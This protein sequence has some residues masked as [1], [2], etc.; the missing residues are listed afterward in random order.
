MKR[1][2]GDGGRWQATKKIWSLLTPPERKGA[3]ALLGLM[4]IGMALETLGV[5]LVIPALALLTGDYSGQSYPALQRLVRSLGNPAP[6]TLIIGGMLTLVGVYA[7]KAA[8]LAFLAWRQMRF[9]FG[10][11]I[12]LSQR[13]FTIYLRQ[14]YAFHLQRNSAQLIR[15]VTTEVSIFTASGILPCT[16]LL[17]E[18]LVLAGLVG[19]LLVIEPIGA[20]IVVTVLGTAGW[21]FQRVTRERIARWGKARQYHEGLRLQHLQQG[22]GATKDVKLLGRE[23]DFLEQFRSHNAKSGRIAQRKSTL[24]QLPRLWLELIAISGLAILVISMVVQGRPLNAVLPTLGVFAAAAFR[25]IPSINKCLGAMQSLR[26][27]R[28]VIDVLHSELKLALPEN[29]ARSGLIAPFQKY[30]ALNHVSY[31]YP[32]SPSPAVRDVSLTVKRGELVGF[33]G[34][35]GAGKSTLVDVL[36]GLLTPDSG[37]VLVDGE[38][39]RLRLRDWQDQIGYVPQS[40]FL[41]DDTLRR[42]IAFGLSDAQIDDDAVTRA[43]EAAQLGEFIRHLP[44][45]HKTVVGER[46]V[47]LSGGQRQRI[48]IARALYHNPGVLVLD[49]ATSALDN[50]TEGDV[51]EAVAALR[52][53][54]TI[55]IV[56]HRLSTVERCDRLFRLENGRLADEGETA[57]VL[58]AFAGARVTHSHI[59]E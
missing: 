24:Q 21:T 6:S 15:N 38:D 10:V 13:M 55:L 47:R 39:I 7:V 25:I 27:S 4:I 43:I 56:A 17:T 44:A 19:L 5:G 1:G 26:F 8:F 40:I 53:S 54:K 51:M 42:N 31:T 16:V 37:E 48:G 57:E 32:G 2:S 22:L 59:G 36:L 41:T 52:G 58:G 23:S 46:G 35:S 34:A 45:G 12:E 28:P 3:A 20:A 9:A 30:L 18:S 29:A 33:I 14:P 50:D 49:E 11:Q